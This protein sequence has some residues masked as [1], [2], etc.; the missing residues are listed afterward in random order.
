MSLR[1]FASVGRRTA[2]LAIITA[3]IAAWL[4]LPI[5]PAAWTDAQIE[6]LSSLWIGSLESLPPD[7]SN[8]VAEN[9]AAASFG[10]QLFFDTRLSAN[11]AISCAT[12]HQPER[13][14][15]DGLPK[16]QAI[17]T[18]GRNTS[19]IVGVAY[20]P[21]L[22]WDGRRDSLWS[23]ALSPLEDSNEHGSDRTHIVAVVATDPSYS[24]IYESLFGAAPGSPDSHSVDRTFANIGKAI[25]AYERLLMPGPSRFD[26]YV[27]AV[28]ARD[29]QS[30]KEIFSDDEVFGL[31]LFIGEA[32]CTQC[33]NG[34]LL[35][36]HEFHNTGVIAF[37]GEVP[38][39]GRVV[40]V[41]DV[42]EDPFNCLGDYSDGSDCA[43]LIFAR[44]GSEL[45][46]AMRTPS[47]R[48]LEN[49]GPFMHKGQIETLAQV[50]QHYNEAPP[51]MIGHNEAQPLDLSGRELRQLEVFLRT[52]A[53]PLATADQWLRPPPVNVEENSGDQAGGNA[54]G[55][56]ILT[57]VSL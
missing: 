38:D 19:S 15:T 31:Q 12:C 22:Y 9:S 52:L 11:G 3:A 14:F 21:W 39:K 32:N 49:T 40:G 54:S 13:R 25:A 27:E 5:W 55:D 57:T 46:G 16:G 2:A 20:S 47:L 41:R 30:Q 23:Q 48:N 34:P 4:L 7:P 35:S 51:A 8:A 28:V 29:E 37:A 10:Q 42:L 17:G 6:T 18:S 56:S 45:I 24:S 36:N 44:T 53:A 26:R 1:T 50:L 43:E 33:H